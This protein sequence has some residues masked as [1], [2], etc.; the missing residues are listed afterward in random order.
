MPNGKAVIFLGA[1]HRGLS[2][3]YHSHVIYYTRDIKVTHPSPLFNAAAIMLHSSS[4]HCSFFQ[5]PND[6]SA[7]CSGGNYRPRDNDFDAE[8]WNLYEP[9]DYEGAPICFQVVGRRYE[10]ERVVAVSKLLEDF[11]KA[12]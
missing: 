3:E 6:K 10:D 9:S 1:R 11:L 7:N 2:F 8:N 12:N 4:T 5:R